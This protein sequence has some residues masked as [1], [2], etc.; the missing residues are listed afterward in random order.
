M[1]P[2]IEHHNRSV[3]NPRIPT[4]SDA[5]VRSRLITNRHIQPIYA[6]LAIAIDDGNVRAEQDVVFQGHV[7]QYAVRPHINAP[8]DAS[9]A[10]G[11][12]RAESDERIAAAF[13]QDHAVESPP[14]I[15]TRHARPQ[16]NELAHPWKDAICA[17][18]RGDGEIRD[19]QRRRNDSGNQVGDD[20]ES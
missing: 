12:D 3:S 9:R 17:D 20:F 18:G 2:D 8:A 13:G 5:R 10:V 14:H 1:S 4:N 11:E 19:R 7:A 6:V 15:R 16:R